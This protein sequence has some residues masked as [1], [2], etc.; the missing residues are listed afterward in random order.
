[1]ALWLG[2]NASRSASSTPMTFAQYPEYAGNDLGVNWSPERTVFKLW[3]PAAQKVRLQLY[4]KGTGGIP[5][6]IFNLKKSEKG[7][8]QTTLKGNMQ[9]KFYTV[10]VQ[11]AD[12]WLAETPDPYAKAVGLNGQRGM[13]VDLKATNPTGWDQDPRPA[14]K[15]F[16]DIILYE[17]HV[18]DLSAHINSGITHRGKFLGLTETGTHNLT[19]QRTGL[20]HFRELGITHLHLLPVFDF[21]SSSIDESKP[22]TP[23]YNWGRNTIIQRRCISSYIAINPGS[24]GLQS[25]RSRNCCRERLSY[26]AMRESNRSL[27]SFVTVYHHGKRVFPPIAPHAILRGQPHSRP[28]CPGMVQIFAN[29]T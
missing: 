6:E 11:I 1:M 13:I 25:V 26:S 18:R 7:V 27:I 8:W 28:D 4:E 15:A 16:T 17:L 23:Q 9:G 20:D 5:L 2:C 29:T 22:E 21:R 3:S 12:K 24:S 14:Q 19:N 10:Q